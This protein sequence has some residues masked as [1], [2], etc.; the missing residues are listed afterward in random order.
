M[1]ARKLVI[2]AW[3]ALA[4]LGG[5]CAEEGG[6]G[7]AQPAEAGTAVEAYEGDLAFVDGLMPHDLT[8][9]WMAEDAIAKARHP[10]LRALAVKLKAARAEEVAALRRQR[11]ALVND[12]E[13]PPIEHEPLATVPAGRDFDARWAAAMAKHQQAAIEIAE[14]GM[15]EAA[16]PEARAMAK[17]IAETQKVEQA[18]LQR[19]ATA[20]QED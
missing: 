3:I 16:T 8:A 11:Q 9:M 4:L 1:R 18:Q 19:W 7:G 15:Y 13:F 14:R 5:G 10:Q 2:G 17:R 6:G 20:G 12:A